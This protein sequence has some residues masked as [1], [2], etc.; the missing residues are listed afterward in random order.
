[1]PGPQPARPPL[2][3]EH[4][5][6]LLTGELGLSRAEVAELGAAG[7]VGTPADAPARA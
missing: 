3:G 1:M 5:V 6:A 2:L 4:T 7:I